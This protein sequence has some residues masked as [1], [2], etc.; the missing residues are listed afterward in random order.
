MWHIKQLAPLRDKRKVISYFFAHIHILHSISTLLLAIMSKLRATQTKSKPS[1]K[2]L[3]W[4]N[5]TKSFN[6][7]K[8]VIKIGCFAKFTFGHG[9][10]AHPQFRQFWLILKKIRYEYPTYYQ[11][12]TW[13]MTTWSTKNEKKTNSIRKE[14]S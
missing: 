3:V 8:L 10:T 13:N 5:H 4:V 6:I 9:V 1:L 14:T 12:T 7:L 2:I 11:P